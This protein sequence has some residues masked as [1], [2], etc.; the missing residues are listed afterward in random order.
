MTVRTANVVAPVLATPKVVVLF[1]AGMARK[2][3]LGNFFGRL[4]L[5]GDDLLRIAFFG[6]GLA[7][8]M[9]LFTARNFPFPTADR[10]KLGM[11]SM[12]EG[13]ELIFMAG[14]ADF[15]SYVVRC[16]VAY[17]FGLRGLD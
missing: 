2:A 8:S 1:F 15:T 17:C 7:R 9:T 10:G 12:R 14:L 3:R 6:V 11:R 13:L 4:V 5:K 16:V